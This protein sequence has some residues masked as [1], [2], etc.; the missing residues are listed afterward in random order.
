M[1]AGIFVLVGVRCSRRVHVIGVKEVECGF[2]AERL[3]IGAR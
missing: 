2:V 1:T 3:S